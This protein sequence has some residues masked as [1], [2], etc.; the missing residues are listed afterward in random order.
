M[1]KF[2]VRRVLWSIPVLLLVIFLTFLLMKAIP[3]G[4]FTREKAVPGGDPREHERQVRAGPAVVHAVRALCLARRA[5]RSRRLHDPEGPDGHGGHRERVP[6]VHASGDSWPSFW[7]CSSAYRPASSPR[8][9]TTRGRTTARSST[10]ASGGPCPCS[11]SARSS[12]IIFSI[13]LGWFPTSRWEGPKYWVLPTVV[14][15]LALSAYF[16][17]LTRGSMLETLQQDYVRT[18]LAKGLSVPY[19]HDEARAPQLADPGGHAGGT[20]ARVSSS[21][22]ASSPSTSSRSPGWA[23]TTCPASRTG[24]TRW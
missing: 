8:S 13:R 2:V 22:V 10:P 18:A 15:G 3:G 23:S 20:A 24:T 19:R 21:P 7:P 11:S 17:R 16:A 6:G 1:F 4:P 14:L 9:S 5:G 12:S